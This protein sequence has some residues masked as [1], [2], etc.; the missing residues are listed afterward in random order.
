MGH[1]PSMNQSHQFLLQKAIEFINCKNYNSAEIFLNQ[2]IKVDSRNTEAFRHLGIIKAINRNYELAN[3]YFDRAIKIAPKNYYA[4]CNKGSVL[5]K[6]KK[7]D[8]ALYCFDQSIKLNPTHYEAWSNKGILYFDFL[9]FESALSAYEKAISIKSDFLPA[10]LNKANV[11][12]ALNQ[13]TQ[14]ENIFLFLRENYPNYFAAR[15]NYSLL[16]LNQ[17]R[18]LEGWK[19]YEYR[20]LNPD[21]DSE[22]LI[23]NKKKWTGDGPNKNILIWAEQGVGDQVLYASMFKD[24]KRTNNNFTSIVDGKLIDIFKY[25]FPWINFLSKAEINNQI[26]DEYDSH[27]PIASLG[28][29]FRIDLD[30]FKD[31]GQYLIS[32][33]AEGSSQKNKKIKCGIS[34]RSTN[35]SVGDQKSFSL[36]EFLKIFIGLDF[37]LVNLQYDITPQEKEYLIKYSASNTITDIDLYDDLVSTMDLINNCDVTVTVS[38]SMA[39]FAGALSKPGIVLTPFAI[40]KFWY[41]HENYDRSLWYPSLRVY[42]QRSQGDWTIPIN[43]SNHFLKDNFA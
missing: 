35:S 41:W 26:I 9:Y 10:I 22:R 11:L 24:L 32:K 19:E 39:H 25:S 28:Q 7:F 8:E 5:T 42:K 40:G 43:L 13:E 18:F 17:K 34:W 1:Q 23:V 31:G 2:L 29:L 38:N 33:G 3:Y 36:E 14:A 30:S 37:E 27:I 12:L 15:Y 21:F 20:W 4:L 6:Q 16:L